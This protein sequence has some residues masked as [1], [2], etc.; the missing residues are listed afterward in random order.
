M[1]HLPAFDNA[2]KASLSSRNPHRQRRMFYKL[3]FRMI[4][5]DEVMRYM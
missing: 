5:A 4:V 2:L 1:T 3:A